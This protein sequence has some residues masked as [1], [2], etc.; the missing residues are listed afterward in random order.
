MIQSPRGR[1]WLATVLGALI[2]V[3]G[4]AAARRWRS[5]DPVPRLG[6]VSST[7]LT[8]V[9]IL[10]SLGPSASYVVET[11]DGLVLVDTGLDQAATQLKVEM[12]RLGLDWKAVRAVLLTHAHGDHSGGAEYLHSAAGAKVY[13]GRGD[14][15]VL[16]SGGPREAFFSTFYMPDQEPHPTRVD[17]ELVGGES[18]SFGDVRFQALAMPGHTPGSICYLMEKSSQRVLFGGDVITMLAGDGSSHPRGL[19]PLGTYSAFLPPRYRG[20][21]KTYLASLRKLSAMPVPDLVLPGHPLSDPTPQSPRLTEQ[22]WQAMLGGGIREMETLLARYQADGAN[23]LDGHPGRLLADLYYLGDFEGLAIY[24]FF[25]G[26]K[27]FL[28]DAP[29]G[30]GLLDYVKARLQELGLPPADPTAVLLTS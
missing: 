22:Q 17:V 1:V 8:G 7:I 9:Y 29:G 10:C 13:A 27:L 6:P 20:D 19:K 30:A 25:V 2:G 28:V 15:A 12:S 24:A 14:A 4:Y 16:K 23:F 26:G 21:A 5:P 11:T 3:S 18:I